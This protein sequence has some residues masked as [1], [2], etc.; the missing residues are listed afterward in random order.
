MLAEWESQLKPLREPPG[1][2][3]KQ[4]F[5]VRAKKKAQPEKRRTS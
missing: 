4:I 1:G 2:W 5:E 3:L